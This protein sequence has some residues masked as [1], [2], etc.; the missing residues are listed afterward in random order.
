MKHLSVVL[1]VCALASPLAAFANERL[2]LQIP[3]ILDPSAPILTAVKNECSL[4]MLLGNYAL[5]E[6]DKRVGSVQSVSAPE[7]AGSGKLVQLTITSAQGVGGGVWTGSKSMSIRVD[8]SKEGTI[9]DSTVLTRSTKGGVY[10][11][12]A[13][14]FFDRMTK[15][16]GKDVAVWLSRGSAAQPAQ[17]VPKVAEPSDESKSSDEPESPATE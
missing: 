2:F 9:F 3:A 16:L 5:S 7:Q 10:G 4:E 13:C 1:L 17:S 15:A 12:S 14:V 8:V 11:G 6:I